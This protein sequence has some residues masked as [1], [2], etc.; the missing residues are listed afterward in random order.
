MHYPPMPFSCNTHAMPMQIVDDIL[1]LTASAS[2]LGK[3]AH[4]DLRS[5]LATAPV[6]YAAEVCSSHYARI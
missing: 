1:D 4:N 2:L 6:L 5:G 3:P